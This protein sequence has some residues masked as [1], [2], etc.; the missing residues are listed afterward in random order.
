MSS[1]PEPDGLAEAA[2]IIDSVDVELNGQ[3]AVKGPDPRQWS[4]LA[5]SN[6]GADNPTPQG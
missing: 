5:R 4:E 2:G 3:P 1:V 6:R